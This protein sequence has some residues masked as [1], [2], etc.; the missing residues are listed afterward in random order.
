MTVPEKQT[1]KN[2]NYIKRVNRK[3]KHT[4]ANLLQ[5]N[6]KEAE[7]VARG[8]VGRPGG[9]CCQNLEEQVFFLQRRVWRAETIQ[10][11]TVRD[12]KKSQIVCDRERGN[13]NSKNKTINASVRVDGNTIAP[14]V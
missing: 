12:K 7:W 1:T 14:V 4:K 6:K 3:Y 13:S 10:R 2:N 8:W 9:V 5:T 11:T